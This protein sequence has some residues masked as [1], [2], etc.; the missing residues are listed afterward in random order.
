MNKVYGVR[1]DWDGLIEAYGTLEE[2]EKV[3]ESVKES[4]M[5][6]GVNI[7]ESFVSIVESNDEFETEKEIK[8]ANVVIDHK[9]TKEIGSPRSNGFDFDYWAE[10]Q[11]QE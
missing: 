10:W 11:E 5:A 8:R 9:L 4:K 6:D 1:D 3:Y 2:A 7:N